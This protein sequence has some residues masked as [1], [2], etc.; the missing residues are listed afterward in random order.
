MYISLDRRRVSSGYEVTSPTRV[1]I[2]GI[3]KPNM[4]CPTLKSHELISFKA[5]FRLPEDVGWYSFVK[6]LIGWSFT[7]TFIQNIF[8]MSF[9]PV[10]GISSVSMSQV[11]ILE[12]ANEL[13][14]KVVEAR[15]ISVLLNV[16]FYSWV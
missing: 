2:T 12:V 4:L 7:F 5:P 8:L 10:S 14:S 9:R 13:R 1:S 11:A 16:Y 15:F 6:R 3:S